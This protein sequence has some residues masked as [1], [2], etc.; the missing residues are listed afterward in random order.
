MG[1]YYFQYLRYSYKKGNNHGYPLNTM[2]ITAPAAC[3]T[4]K[5]S[6]K[7]YDNL[8]HDIFNKLSAQCET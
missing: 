2:Y 6:N 7:K 5:Q 3:N 4:V 1:L 8:K